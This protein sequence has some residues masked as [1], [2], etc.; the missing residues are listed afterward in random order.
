MLKSVDCV[1]FGYGSALVIAAASFCKQSE[2]KDTA[3][4]T[5]TLKAGQRPEK[6]KTDN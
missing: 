5:A 4:S 1:Y 3:E 2:V 6:I